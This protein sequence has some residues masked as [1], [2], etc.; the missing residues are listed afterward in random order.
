MRLRQQTVGPD[1]SI[2]PYL[3]KFSVR[4]IIDSAQL[5]YSR[6]LKTGERR[7]AMERERVAELF[8]R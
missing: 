7:G 3:I 2:G 6:D 4:V 1:E 8:R 5:L